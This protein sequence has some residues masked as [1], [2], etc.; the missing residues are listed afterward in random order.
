MAD[1]AVKLGLDIEQ[2]KTPGTWEYNQYNLYGLALS[3]SPESKQNF[4]RK[5]RRPG[6]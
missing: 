4:L 6:L 1:Y 3:S 5:L 2:V